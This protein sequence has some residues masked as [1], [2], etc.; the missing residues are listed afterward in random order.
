MLLKNNQIRLPLLSGLLL[1]ASWPVNGL[2]FLAF[3]A[4]IPL[5]FAEEEWI[6]GKH[7]RVTF[8]LFYYSPFLIWNILTTWWIWN[9]SA[10]GAIMAIVCNALLMFFVFWL[11]SVTTRKITSSLRTFIFPFYW[12]SFEYLHHDW[13]LTWPWLTLGNNLANQT[14]FI[15]WYEYT[16][17]F[18]GS[19]WILLTNSLLF[20]LIKNVYKHQQPVKEN[21]K[22]LL[23]TLAVIIIPPIASILILKNYQEAY[24]PVQV[25]IVQPNIDPYT[26]K[27]TT[28]TQEYQLHKALQLASTETDAA[29]DLI[30]TPET[31]LPQNINEDEFHLT[32]EDTIIHKFLRQ[33]PKLALLMGVST[34]KIYEHPEDKTATA[35]KFIDADVYYDVFNTAAYFTN[36]QP[37]QFYHKSK[38][39]PGVEKM[40]FPR[41]FKFFEKFAINLGGTTGSLGV[42]KEPTVFCSKANKIC[43]APIICYESIYGEWTGKFIKKGANLIGIITND[44]WWGDTPGYKQHL[45]YARMLAIEHRRSVVRSANTG[46]SAVINQTGNIIAKTRWWEEATL[47]NTVNLNNKLTFYSKF[48]DWPA[49]LSLVVSALMI[50]FYIYSRFSKPVA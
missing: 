22:Q 18:G 50:L 9:A 10:G 38:L 24:N 23:L 37:N 29:T 14:R 31:T 21:S 44:G 8:F 6:N 25:I 35:R 15:Q 13:D 4:F 32:T 47:K 19:W 49:H 42:Q 43:V 7:Q 2:N 40:P 34:L 30:I 36:T 17:P 45:T 1:A 3:I 28:L 12:I 26:E 20:N 48:G 16:G 41:F 5:F 39:V 33:N 27:F 11:W 46:I